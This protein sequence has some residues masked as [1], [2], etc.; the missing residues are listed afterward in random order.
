MSRRTLVLLAAGILVCAALAAWVTQQTT[1][2]SQQQ[3]LAAEQ[4]TQR[5]RQATEQTREASSVPSS[6]QTTEQTAQQSQQTTRPAQRSLPRPT[7][8]T[9]QQSTEPPQQSPEPSKKQKF[10]YEQYASLSYGM[11]VDEAEKAMGAPGTEVARSTAVV[12]L[13]WRNLDRTGCSAAFA[14][15]TERLRYKGNDGLSPTR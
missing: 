5:S 15:S 12:I 14:L 3:Q 7:Q 2:Q 8:Q 13:E 4:D 1:Q 11:T 10:T 9:T 6:Q